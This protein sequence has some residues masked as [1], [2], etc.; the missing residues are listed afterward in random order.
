[1]AGIREDI[2]AQAVPRHGRRAG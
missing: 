2:T 1:M